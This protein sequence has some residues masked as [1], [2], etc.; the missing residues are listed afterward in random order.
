MYTPTLGEIER[1]IRLNKRKEAVEMLAS[2]LREKPSS[3]AWYLAAKLSNDP[4]KKVKYLRTALLMDPSH[5]KSKA[6]MK[7]LG[8]DAGGIQHVF[9][10]EF[11]QFIEQQGQKSP[12]LRRFPVPLQITSFFAVIIFFIVIVSLLLSNLFGGTGPI[13]S[14]EGPQIL[15]MQYFTATDLMNHFN[16]SDLEIMYVTESQYDMKESIRLEIRDNES[17]LRAIDIIVYDSLHALIADR[18]SLSIYEQYSKVVAHSNA[19]LIYPPEISEVFAKRL[20]SVFETV[21]PQS[22]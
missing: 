20:I 19:V 14:E 12:I 15:K 8:A 13:L 6:L 10:A 9:V 11:I 18:P 4:K 7:E 2:V 21:A 17:R 22:S 3:E 1:A 16:A 5:R